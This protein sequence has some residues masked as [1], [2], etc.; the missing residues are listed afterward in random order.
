MRIFWKSKRA[1][2]KVKSYNPETGEEVFNFYPEDYICNKDLGEEEEKFWIN[3]AW[4]GTK[5][6]SDIYINMRPRV[7]QYNTLD[8]PSRCHFG[9]V[10]SIYNLNESKPFSLVDMMKSYN[11]LYDLI[12][13]RL[14]KLIAR[15]Y[16][17]ILE[18]DLAKVPDG[19]TIDKWLYFAQTQGI[20]VSDSFKESN[21]GASTGKLAGYMNNASRGVI[22]ADWGNNIQQY[23][24]LLEFI[25]LEMSEVVGITKQRE[26]QI[27]NRETVGGVERATLQSSHITEWTFA[28]HDDVKK[29]ALTCFLE[30]SKVAFKGRTKKF[31]YILPDYSSVMMEIN[32]DDFAENSYGLVVDNSEE[33]QRLQS[34]YETLAQAALQNQ[35]LK[36]STIMKLYSSA[37]I[38]EKQRLIEED[39]NETMAAQQQ[40]LQQEQQ[41]EQQKL[42]AAN[43]LEIVKL[44]QED[45]LNERD[46]EVKLLIANI[47][48]QNK[49]NIDNDGIQEPSILEKQK[50][51]ESIRQFNAK[52][53]LDKEKLNLEKKKAEEDHNYK[54]K[55]LSK[56]SVKTS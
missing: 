36:F 42:E 50:L 29:R 21:Q 34:Q 17:K 4:E 40:A 37:S 20:A 5:I 30:T 54:M 6:G 26:G 28:I 56:K 1:I 9:I 22:D 38:A 24:N 8:N 3:Q 15:N 45:K 13:D 10:G 27:S 33:T 39:E 48:A 46:N 19:W 52:L 41:L 51:E 2:K 18:L 16:G 31:E 55:S 14:V 23:I 47:N 12:H 53:K 7:V 11:Y 35:K 25:K 49:S 43:Q 44:E 32:G